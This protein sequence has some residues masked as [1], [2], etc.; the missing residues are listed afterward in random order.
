V[1][2]FL[3]TG[4]PMMIFGLVWSVYQWVHTYRLGVLATTGTVMIGILPIVL[5]FQLILQA[6]VLDVGNEPKRGR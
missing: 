6:V 2:I 4:L 3:V 5:G 1:S